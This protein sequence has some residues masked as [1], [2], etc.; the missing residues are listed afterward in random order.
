MGRLKP[1]GICSF[2]VVAYNR[3][4]LNHADE[5]ETIL[6][7]LEGYFSWQYAVHCVIY[8]PAFFRQSAAGLVQDCSSL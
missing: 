6:Q 5:A 4:R 3:L 2:L 1:T 7:L 8:K